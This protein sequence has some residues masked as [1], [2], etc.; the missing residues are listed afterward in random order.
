[1]EKPI[2]A[3]KE[4]AIVELEGGKTYA[5]CSCGKSFNQ[6][7]CSGAHRGTSFTPLLF[8]IEKN[9]SE[10]LCQCKQTKTPPFCDGTHMSL[11]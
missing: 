6:P 10:L 9:K 2:I 7:W 5:W 1:M 3:S 4:P 11:L 8:K